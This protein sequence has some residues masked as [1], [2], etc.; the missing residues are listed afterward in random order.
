M[1]EWFD[2]LK[3]GMRFKSGKTTVSREDILRFAAEFDPQPFHL[4]EEAAKQTIF[5]GLAASGW[6]TAAIAMIS[7]F[8]CGHS[9]RIRFSERVSMTSDGRNR[10]GPA[11][12]FTSK[13]RWSNWSPRKPSRKAS[14]ASNGPPITSTARRSTPLTRSESYRAGLPN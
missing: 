2:D 13:A 4:D 5:K 14:C 11:T 6:H 3:L 7:R 12:R 8:K 10:Y 9:G 1:I